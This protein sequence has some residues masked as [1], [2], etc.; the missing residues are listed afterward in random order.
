MDA[1]TPSRFAATAR[2]GALGSV[3]DDANR[4]AK[5]RRAT[6][7]AAGLAALALG[8]GLFLATGGPGGGSTRGSS[9]GAANSRS[10]QGASVPHTVHGGPFLGFGGIR[11]P[12]GG[13]ALRHKRQVLAQPTAVGSAAIWTAPDWAVPGSCAWLTIGQAVY[14]G[15]CRRSDPPRR[16]LSEVVPLS[17]RVKGH[18]VN[19]LWGIVGTDVASVDLRFQDGRTTS[20]PLT[21]RVFLYVIPKQRSVGG[22][23]RTWLIGRERSGRTLRDRLEFSLGGGRVLPSH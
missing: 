22:Y 9:A 20:I 18:G 2:L 14:G 3:I 19:L 17:L 4:H 7:A 1:S 11:K 16:G 12:P 13:A 10:G 8:L 21:S 6:W 15:E 5:W 23:R